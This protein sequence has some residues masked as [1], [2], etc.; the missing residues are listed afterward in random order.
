MVAR[1]ARPLSAVM[2]LPPRL[3]VRMLITV[4]QVRR[5]RCLTSDLRHRC[6]VRLT[7]TQLLKDIQRP[8]GGEGQGARDIIGGRN[9]PTTLMLWFPAPGAG[10]RWA[11]IKPTEG[12]SACERF[13]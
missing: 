3:P 2:R 13:R 4:A 9:A 8:Q 5:Q 12:C 10:A 11:A 6:R 7:L 1:D